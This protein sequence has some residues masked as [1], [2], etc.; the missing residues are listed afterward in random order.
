MEYKVKM[1]NLLLYDWS[2]GKLLAKNVISK[3]V[4][5]LARSK[6]SFFTFC[7]VLNFIFVLTEHT[8]TD[9]IL[10][11][12]FNS[13]RWYDLNLNACQYLHWCLTATELLNIFNIIL[14][15]MN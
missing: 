1:T 7:L 13:F 15:Q 4:K 8:S 3:L 12:I 14:F 9:C 5:E 2:K 10:L 11:I 6:Y